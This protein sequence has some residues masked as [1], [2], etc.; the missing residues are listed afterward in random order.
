M[1]FLSKRSLEGYLLI[2]NRGLPELTP[3]DL[4]PIN[5]TPH[6]RKNQTFESATVTCNHCQYI[7]ILNPDRTRERTY[8]GKCAHYIC[9]RCAAVKECKTNEQQFDEYTAKVLADE[10]QERSLAVPAP[11][12][13]LRNNLGE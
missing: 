1:S 6:V 8:C 13:L 11:I 12:T 2:D 5:Q 7:V 10:A 4:N 3:V 9:D